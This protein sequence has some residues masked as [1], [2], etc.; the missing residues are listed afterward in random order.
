MSE[1]NQMRNLYITFKTPSKATLLKHLWCY[2]TVSLKAPREIPESHCIFTQATCPWH[3]FFQTLLAY[4]QLCCN[5]SSFAHLEHDLLA[6][7]P[8]TGVPACS[9]KNYNMDPNRLTQ[10]IDCKQD[11]EK[12][13][14][15]QNIL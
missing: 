12:H 5:N 10:A 3:I 14:I 15:Y 4:V 7:L 1:M 9:H 11:R 8:A 6:Y 13:H 2:I